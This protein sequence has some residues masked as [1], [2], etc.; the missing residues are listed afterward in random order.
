MRRSVLGCLGL[1]G[2]VLAAAG[3]ARAETPAD[4]QRGFEAAARQRAPDFSAFSARRGEAFFNARHGSEWSCATCH[5]TDPRQPGRHAATG[6]TIAPLAPSAN[7]ERFT[8]PAEV[9]KWFRRNCNDVLG[10][11]CTPLEKGDVLAWLLSLGR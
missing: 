3:V 7:A 9:D 5:T 8:R 4:I 2:T 11:A 1:I 10:R 6:K